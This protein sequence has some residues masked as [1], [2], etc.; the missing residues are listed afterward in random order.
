MTQQSLSRE[1]REQ[2]ASDALAEQL[3]ALAR[4]LADRVLGRAIELDHEA[5]EAAEAA[6]NTIDYATLRDIAA[7]VGISEDSLKKALLEELNTERDHNARPIERAT[8]PDTVRGGLVIPGTAE[9]VAERLREHLQRVEGLIEERQSGSHTTWRPQNG[10]GRVD[11]WTVAQPDGRR[12]LVEVDVETKPARSNA[13]KWILGIMIL[14][15]L[16]GSAWGSVVLLGL[17]AVGVAT[18]VGFLRRIARKARRTINRTLSQI[19]ADG[20]PLDDLTDD[21]LELFER[22]QK[23]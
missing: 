4:P 19:T 20:G 17:F 22:L 11:T 9:Q 16:G 1:E 18:V 5:R 13:W 3:Q 12:Q 21:W 6:A 2:R 10:R 8:V 15:M 14:S 23:R 7:E